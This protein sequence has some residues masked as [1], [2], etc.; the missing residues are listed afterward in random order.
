VYKQG[1]DDGDGQAKKKTF[2]EIGAKPAMLPALAPGYD[3]S[4]DKEE[5][6]PPEE[7][8]RKYDHGL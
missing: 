5:D 3:P 1:T 4:H 7:D 8:K 2:P 6:N